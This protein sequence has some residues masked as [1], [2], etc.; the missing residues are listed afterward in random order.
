MAYQDRRAPS[1]LSH[2]FL[3][4]SAPV[5]IF[6]LAYLLRQPALHQDLSLPAEF[7]PPCPILDLQTQ[8]AV[9]APYGEIFTPEFHLESDRPESTKT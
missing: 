3:A 6:N 2:F 4:L 7:L 1:T 8:E 9:K 5:R